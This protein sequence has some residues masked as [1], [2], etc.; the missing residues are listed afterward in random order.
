MQSLPS[1][2]ALAFLLF[3]PCVA[4][5][6]SEGPPRM[7]G[8]AGSGEERGEINLFI[9]P[10]GQPFRAKSGEPYPVATWFRAADRNGDGRLTAD[11]FR[12]DAEAF[13]T[14]LDTDRDAAIDGF[15][16]ADYERK[17]APEILPRVAGLRA[18][19]GMDPRI[20]DE[21]GR[22]RGGGEE[23]RGRRE[24]AMAGDRLPQGAGLFSL[25][26][27]PQPV[28][29]ADNDLSGK[30]TPEEW[31]AIAARRFTVLDKAGLGYLSLSTLP[32]TPVQ[33]FAEPPPERN[34]RRPR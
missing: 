15:E 31:R 12:Q 33:P 4:A 32:K 13:F 16:I 20:F 23:G 3:L 1:R 30:I 28:A 17:V 5:C 7:I 27:D 2:G 14:V 11:E 10:A 22:Q 6:A 29:A 25:L 24:R 9:S 21:R 19:E 18:G 34:G 26:P 8:G